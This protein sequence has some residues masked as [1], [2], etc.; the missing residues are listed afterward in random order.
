MFFFKF[1]EALLMLY[2]A[3]VAFTCIS[4]WI[5]V[6]IQSKSNGKQD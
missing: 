2:K 4:F 5:Y 6:F 3:F 1:P